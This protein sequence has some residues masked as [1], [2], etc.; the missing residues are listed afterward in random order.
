LVGQKKVKSGL[1]KKET[2]P[3]WDVFFYSS[4]SSVGPSSVPSAGAASSQS[5]HVSFV[6]SPVLTPQAVQ[7]P[8]P[9][10]EIDLF[11]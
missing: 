6:S 7:I 9:S 4:G 2:R 5:G 10:I 3:D 11:Y 8:V 1:D